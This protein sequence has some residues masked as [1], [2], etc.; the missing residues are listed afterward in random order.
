MNCVILA[1]LIAFSLL[2]PVAPHTPTT[3]APRPYTPTALDPRADCFGDANETACSSPSVVTAELHDELRLAEQSAPDLG[4]LRAG[5]I[6]DNDWQW[7]AVGAG[8]VLLI[9]LL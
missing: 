2:L 6:S 1:P 8:I 3:S 7:L 5:R 9:V 4:S